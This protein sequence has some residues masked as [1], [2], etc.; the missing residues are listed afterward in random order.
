MS[1]TALIS[2][3]DALWQASLD[4]G[5]DARL[6]QRVVDQPPLL[7][8]VNRLGP[9][10]FSFIGEHRADPAFDERHLPAGR[11]QAGRCAVLGC[12]SLAGLLLARLEGRDAS[13][14]L[15]FALA[16]AALA[17]GRS[18]AVAPTRAELDAALQEGA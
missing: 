9:P 2:L 15:R 1:D 18:G 6:I 8:G 17:C 13:E 16:A 10:H 4:A 11:E 5:P 12:I 7:V 3:S 14:Q